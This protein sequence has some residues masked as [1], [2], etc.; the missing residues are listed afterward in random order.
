[1]AHGSKPPPSFYSRSNFFISSF[2]RSG[3]HIAS[4]LFSILL[5]LPL[6]PWPP[7][8]LLQSG[9]FRC[10][11]AQENWSWWFFQLIHVFPNRSCL[12][13]L[14]YFING[15]SNTHLIT[16]I[17]I[18]GHQ[19][20]LNKPSQKVSQPYIVHEILYVF[21]ISIKNDCF[22]GLIFLLH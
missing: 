1:M 17:V 11:M 5:L 12:Y 2:K 4:L 7:A 6:L 10:T 9:R 13:P 14:N 18:S 16:T 8:S 22:I 21:G 3:V 19:H 15:R 20:C